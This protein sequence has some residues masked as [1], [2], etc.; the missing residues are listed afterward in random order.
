MQKRL[1][2]V[3]FGVFLFL[4]SAK[5]Q[6]LSF[7][8]LWENYKNH[9]FEMQAAEK[10]LE[11]S[12]LAKKRADLHWLPRVYVG[13]QWFT[14]NDPGQVFFNN[15]GQRA[16]T[17][18]DFVPGELNRPGMRTFKAGNLGLDLPLYEG[19]MKVAQVSLLRQMLKASE[20]EAKAKKTAEYGELSRRYGSLMVREQ[21]IVNLKS[22]QTELKKIMSGY[23]VGA[24]SN[25]VGYSGLLGLKGVANR[26]EALLIQHNL[27]IETDR[28]WINEK[29]KISQAGW[30]PDLKK[31]LNS[32]LK[33]QY[34]STSGS[35]LSSELL[36][37]SL[38]AETLYHMAEMEKARFLPRVGVFAQNNLYSGNRDT[39]NSQSLGLYLMWELFNPDSYGRNSEAQA[40]AMAAEAKIKNARLD[41]SIALAKLID[42][43]SALEM[44]LKLLDDSDALL[45]EQS[46][47]AMKLFRSGLLSALQLTEVISRRI[48]LIEEKSQTQTNYLEVTS[49]I[50]Q[51][52][53]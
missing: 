2:G 11:A 8:E 33:D 43:K 19:G 36:A 52:R 27:Q 41:E 24:K 49:R 34:Q 22:L 28:K 51:I 38:K 39:E 23:Q 7:E 21:I 4:S 12:T 16:I 29:A 44:G 50:H 14:T 9:S 53:N 3:S 15:L 25:P 5:A 40:R 45:G 6:V 31:G 35:A 48:D 17:Q 30:K 20:A 42:S 47:N 46:I 13:G 32:F 1:V 26:I 18:M 10:E 37:A